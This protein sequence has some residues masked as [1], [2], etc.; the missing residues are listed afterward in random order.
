GSKVGTGINAGNITT[1]TLSTSRGGL[2][3]D[4]SAYGTGLYGTIS[5]AATNVNTFTLLRSATGITGTPDGTKFLR[6]DG[7]LAAVPG[8]ALQVRE[9]DGSPTVSNVSQIRVT[10]GGLTDNGA[11]SVSLNLAGAGGGG[12]VVSSASVSVDG[13]MPLFNGTTGKQIK[14]STLTGGLLQSTSGVPGSV[15]TSAGV[16]ALITDETGTNL[17]V[18][19]NGPTLVSPIFSGATIA[20][21]SLSSPIFASSSASPAT[22][23]ILRLANLDPIAWKTSAA[24]ATLFTDAS[25]VM[26]SSVTFNAPTLTEGGSAVPN[27]TDNITFFSSATSAQWFSRISDPVGTGRVVFDTNANLTPP[28]FV[29]TQT[30][31]D[32][33]LYPDA[34]MAGT[35]IDT[36]KLNNTV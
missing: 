14:R 18:F 24:D 9:E 6:D 11:G 21:T 22:S 1:G 15:N 35:V 3:A 10:N 30:W 19:S 28:T 8:A 33:Y 12:D 26:Q 7:T 29:G 23:G 25:R 36:S 16:S 32:N 31:S 20:T 17:L 34:P 13:E 2:G 4:V 5:G 27:S